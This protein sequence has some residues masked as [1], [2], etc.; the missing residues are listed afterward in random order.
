VTGAERPLWTAALKGDFD[1]VGVAV[2]DSQEF[3][4]LRDVMG[5]A[6]AALQRL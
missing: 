4:P 2:R 5:E 1:E 6:L 3:P